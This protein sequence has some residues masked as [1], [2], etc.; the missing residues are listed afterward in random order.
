MWFCLG[1]SFGQYSVSFMCS[2]HGNSK[3]CVDFC[4]DFCYNS[5]E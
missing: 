3:K 2:C 5:R 1:I 4:M